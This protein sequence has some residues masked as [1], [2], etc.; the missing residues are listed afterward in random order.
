MRKLR[1]RLESEVQATADADGYYKSPIRFTNNEQLVRLK[2]S[3]VGEQQNVQLLSYL[4]NVGEAFQAAGEDGELTREEAPH[5]NV[6]NLT[7][8]YTIPP[9]EIMVVRHLRH[10]KSMKPLL[11]K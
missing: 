7:T 3:G 6:T 10:M 9:R 5:V 1:F 8:A 11:I 4:G 2:A